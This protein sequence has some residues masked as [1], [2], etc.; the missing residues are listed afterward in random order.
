MKPWV[1]CSLTIAN[2]LI[3]TRALIASSRAYSTGR[4]LLLSPSP[5]MSMTRRTLSCP[6]RSNCFIAKS[7]P[8][9]IAVAPAKERGTMP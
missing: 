2:P 1:G 6:L 3:V 9:P 4:P 7:M 5:E 8:A